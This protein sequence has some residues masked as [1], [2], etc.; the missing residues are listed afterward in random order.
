MGKMERSKTDIL[1]RNLERDAQRALAEDASFLEALQ[2]LKWEVDSD[3][4]VKAATQALRGRG[5][6]V[7]SS[8]APRIRIGLHAGEDVLALPKDSPASNPSDV[9][10]LGYVSQI[11]SEAVTQELRDAATA[12]VSASPYCR[13]LDRI[14][15]EALHA[16]CRFERI[17]AALE[18]AGYELHICLD[19]SAYA[20]VYERRSDG[21]RSPEYKPSRTGRQ[22]RRSRSNSMS[23]G[24][25]WQLPLSSED[26]EFLR[27]LRITP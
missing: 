8:F 21:A 15:S 10:D 25:R 6:V 18:C 7:Y 11:V 19:L 24:N 14:V 3:T 9:E 12:V 27:R 5:L 17:A 4:R 2:S 13:Q 22:P 16:S 1:L 23:S 20:R 26:I